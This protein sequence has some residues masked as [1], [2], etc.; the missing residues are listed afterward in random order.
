MQSGK[1]EYHF[2]GCRSQ[3]E[4]CEMLLQN[5]HT[6]TSTCPSKLIR[7]V[8]S[9][10]ISF[11]VTFDMFGFEIVWC[12][13]QAVRL[14]VWEDANLGANYQSTFQPPI[15]AMAKKDCRYGGRCNQAWCWCK[16]FCLAR[17]PE[18]QGMDTLPRWVQLESL[19]KKETISIT[20][21]TRTSHTFVSLVECLGMLII[22]A[23]TQ[24]REMRMVAPI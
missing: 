19:R 9:P 15:S 11:L 21:D 12:P 2:R 24:R 7:M 20:Y 22:I 18:G 13:I 5:N 3:H 16:R 6:Y 8:L 1:L 17:S 23:Q 4:T 14:E 10:P